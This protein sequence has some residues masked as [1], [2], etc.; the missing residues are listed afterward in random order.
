MS[1]DTNDVPR[2]LYTGT[3]AMDFNDSQSNH[4][5]ELVRDNDFRSS[6]TGGAEA[7]LP[8]RRQIVRFRLH[9]PILSRLAAIPAR[10]GG[11]AGP[12]R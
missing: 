8:S 11:G 3:Q 7:L 2:R 9:E 4:P 10:Q 6:L 5:T 1:G 12:C